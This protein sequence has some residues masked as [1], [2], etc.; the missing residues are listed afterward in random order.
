MSP[1]LSSLKTLPQRPGLVPL[2]NPYAPKSHR[3]GAGVVQSYKIASSRQSKIQQ[4]SPKSIK[5]NE[6][7]NRPG[8]DVWAYT[9]GI[10]E[11]QDFESSGDA[12]AGGGNQ[13]P[14]L[15]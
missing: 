10:Q 11:S 5:E 12:G 13:S 4:L 7:R 1:V 9:R 15:D 8:S 3:T 6:R 14:Y 2:D